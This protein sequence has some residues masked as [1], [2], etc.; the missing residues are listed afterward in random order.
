M[1]PMAA[2]I[3]TLC[4]IFL[5]IAAYRRSQDGGMFEVFHHP[6]YF[7]W[8][9]SMALPLSIV[10]VH[11]ISL[12]FSSKASLRRKRQRARVRDG[13]EMANVKGRTRSSCRFWT[14]DWC[15]SDTMWNR[16]KTHTFA[17]YV[18]SELLANISW[19]SAIE[20]EH[21]FIHAVLEMFRSKPAIKRN[22]YQSSDK[23][24][25][26]VD[27]WHKA[28]FLTVFICNILSMDIIERSKIAVFPAIGEVRSAGSDIVDKNY[29]KI[30]PKK[31]QYYFQV[32]MTK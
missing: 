1:L 21:V 23:W 18:C 27:F 15:I 4:D 16:L 20:P 2:P 13:V 14:L 25:N 31:I 12:L 24:F 11:A 7:A 28:I 29:S 5:C 8:D 22:K 9:S 19:G 3:D 26:P 30:T 10:R 17:L 32:D 6:S